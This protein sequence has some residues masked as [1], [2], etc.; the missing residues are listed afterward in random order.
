ME[1]KYKEVLDTFVRKTNDLIHIFIGEEEIVTTAD[2]PFWVEG[3]G[4]VPAMSL[5]IDSELLNNSG[6]VVC[7][8][9]LLRETNADGAEVYNFK[10]DEYHTYY[11]G[12]MH[13]LVHNAGDAYS[14][15]SG[16]QKRCKR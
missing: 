16:I 3:K 7:V 10:V 5:V 14:R 2:H 13:I 12:D 11:V 6:N 9:N 8:D 1:R 15:P 4:F